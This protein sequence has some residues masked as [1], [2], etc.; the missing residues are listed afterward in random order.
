MSYY[1]REDEDPRGFNS[2]GHLDSLGLCI[3]LAFVKHFNAGFP[4]MV[5]DD[6]VSSIDAR[7]RSHICDLP[8]EEFSDY[9]LFVTTHDYE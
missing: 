3:F 2:E 7:H 8:L 4:L 5:L 6:V 9:Q 1:D